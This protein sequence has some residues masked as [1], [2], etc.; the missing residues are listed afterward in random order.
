MIC[1]PLH[2]VV[3]IRTIYGFLCVRIVS[4]LAALSRACFE[5]EI[6]SIIHVAIIQKT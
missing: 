1:Q 4:Q 3:Q 2:T 6:F 5:I